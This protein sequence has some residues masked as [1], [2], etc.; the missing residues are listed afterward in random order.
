MEILHEQ[1][2]MEALKKGDD[3]A[4]GYFFDLHYKPLCYFAGR[5]VQDDGEA[6][7]IVSSCFV[8]LWKSE[9]KGETAESVK[10]FL[11]I[12]CRNACFDYL[13]KVKVR[14]A[15]QQEYFIQL[16]TADEAI[17][18]KIVKAEVLSFLEREIDYLPDKCRAVFRLFYFERKGTAEVMELLGINEKAV[19]YQKAKAIELL[20]T[21]IVKKGL[22][23]ELVLAL[24]L[25]LNHR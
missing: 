5:L 21:A 23:K 8:K 24:F 25:F 13:R 15:S 3:K 12:A 4:L 10:A 2:W 14:T 19:R 7:D 20:K 1:Y 6:E 11:Y 17:L 18:T 9:R 22:S 16:G